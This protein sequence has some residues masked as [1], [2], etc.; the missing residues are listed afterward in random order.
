MKLATSA[1]VP[2][3]RERV[4]AALVDPEILRRCIPGCE[5]LTASGPDAYEATLRIGVAGLKGS[6]GGKAAIRD[7][8]PPES[9]TLSFEGKGGPGFVR[10]SAA[11]VL[12]EEGGGTRI[13]CA[14]DVQVGGL[15]AAVGSR[16][17]EAAA[18]KLADDFFRQ[19]SQELEQTP[20]A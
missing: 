6:Y 5:T 12:T 20:L 11:I 19:L 2:G 4:F 8:H 10:G 3:P 16:F 14:S 17:V 13:A 9:L 1:V 7:K 15:I 18:K